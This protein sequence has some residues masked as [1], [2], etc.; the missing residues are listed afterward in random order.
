MTGTLEGIGAVLREED[1][2]IKVVSIVPGSASWRQKELKAEGRVVLRSL[3]F[4][5]QR[6]TVLPGS[7]PVV[8]AIA[9]LLARDPG[10][11]LH[12]VVHGDN[13]IPAAAGVDLTKKRAA[14]LVAMLTRGHK[15][16]AGR[17]QPAGVGP[18]APVASSRTEEGRAL[19]RRVELVPNEVSGRR[20]AAASV[21]R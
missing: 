14:A 15:I 16:P 7:E 1:G 19:N 18:L 10:L 8:K 4:Q 21:R 6:A 20:E 9:D 2:Y 5:D 12:V 13:A 3:G 11:K 17:V